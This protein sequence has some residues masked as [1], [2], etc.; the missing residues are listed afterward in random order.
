MTVFLIT[1]QNSVVEVSAVCFFG[2]FENMCHRPA[3]A[4]VQLI[5]EPEQVPGTEQTASPVRIRIQVCERKEL[6]ICE[7]L[8]SPLAHKIQPGFRAQDRYLL[9]MVN[10]PLFRN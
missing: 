2:G 10:L 9:E 4:S 8:S 7:M 6:F 1:Q 3:C 5:C